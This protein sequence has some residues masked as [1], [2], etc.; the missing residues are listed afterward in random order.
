MSSGHIDN[1]MWI[2]GLLFFDVRINEQKKIQI[3]IISDYNFMPQWHVGSMFLFVKIGK[4]D[5]WFHLRFDVYFCNYSSLNIQTCKY[6]NDLFF[7]DGSR[8]LLQIMLG[9]Y[10]K[11]SVGFALTKFC[12]SLYLSM[13]TPSAYPHI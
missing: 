3:V 8:K 6:C 2:C 13:D 11:C 9:G 1:Y 4:K 10:E 7:V 12:W 5:N